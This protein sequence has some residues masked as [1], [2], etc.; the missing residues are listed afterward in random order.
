MEAVA[1]ITDD[2]KIEANERPHRSKL[3][4]DRLTSKQVSIEFNIPDSTLRSW[5]MRR[6]YD[7]R[8]P[9]FHKLFTGK[10]FYV[11]AEIE[12]DLRLMEVDA[13]ISMRLCY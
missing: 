4:N 3:P 12:E 13:D 6:S 8:F 10:V 2:T 1:Q 11:R 5:R 7:R 9:R